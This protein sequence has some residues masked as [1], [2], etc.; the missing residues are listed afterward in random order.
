M[1]RSRRIAAA[2]GNPPPGFVTALPF[3]SAVTALFM[4][5]AVVIYLVTTIAW[6]NAENAL[7]RRGLPARAGARS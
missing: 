1:W 6:S 2:M 4:S 3:L 7:L 5:L